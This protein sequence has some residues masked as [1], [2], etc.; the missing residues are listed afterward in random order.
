MH[1]LTGY[2]CYKEYTLNN[3]CPP[4]NVVPETDIAPVAANCILF[5][6]VPTCAAVTVIVVPLFVAETLDKVL[7]FEVKSPIV[8]KSLPALSPA[9]VKVIS[10]TVTV[11]PLPGAPK[12]IVPV[13]AAVPA[14][15]LITFEYGLAKL[16]VVA[17]NLIL[18]YLT[19]VAAFILP[20]PFKSVLVI[21]V[22]VADQ[23]LSLPSVEVITSYALG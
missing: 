8:I 23:L 21:V 19:P 22:L 10:P 5:P 14:V 11:S 16:D 20:Y 13:A 9:F 12:I 3:Y 4:D 1:D 17:F 15:R 2:A 18:I 7:I 6:A